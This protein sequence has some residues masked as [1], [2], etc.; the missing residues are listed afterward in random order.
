MPFTVGSSSFK[1]GRRMH[2]PKKHMNPVWI[3]F[4]SDLIPYDPVYRE[5]K[6]SGKDS[7]WTR[8]TV[9]TTHIPVDHFSAIEICMQEI[10]QRKESNQESLRYVEC[11]RLIH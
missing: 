1:C 9:H 5:M 4:A 10:T 11:T 2:F 8:I 3:H 6:D 7:M